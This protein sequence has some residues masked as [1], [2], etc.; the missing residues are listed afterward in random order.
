MTDNPKRGVIYAATGE[1]YL[2]TARRS[3]RSLRKYNP[4]LHITLFSDIDDT[5]GCFDRVI[6]IDGAHTRSKVDAIV[7][8]PYEQTLYLDTDTIIRDDLTDMFGLLDRFDICISGV[9]LWDRPG[10]K[11]VWKTK[12]PESFVEPN[13]GVILYRRTEK[14][15]GF[16]E[17]FRKDFY[18]YGS[19]NDQITMRELIWN[20]D[21]QYFVLPEQYN[22]RVIEASELIYTDRPRAKLFHLKLLQPQKNPI[23]NW[24]SNLVR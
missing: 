22:K 15:N 18:E 7:E 8:T 10:H 4:D 11:N 16:L 20:T 2:D 19:S 9:V 17:Q 21:V 5:S 23:K 13:T 6:R 12:T 3:A 14:M 24:I 1:A